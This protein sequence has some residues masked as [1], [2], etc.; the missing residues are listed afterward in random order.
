MIPLIVLTAVIALGA[1]AWR[2]HTCIRQDQEAIATGF[3][4]IRTERAAQQRDRE[5]SCG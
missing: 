2:V 3:A 5:V 1:L 4:A